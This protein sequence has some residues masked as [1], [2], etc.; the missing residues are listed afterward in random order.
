MTE[1]NQE[2]ASAEEEANQFVKSYDLPVSTIV[3]LPKYKW[4]FLAKMLQDFAKQQV[5]K[6]CKEKDDNIIKKLEFM[7]DNGLGWKD[8]EN[9][10]LPKQ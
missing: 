5:E 7:I 2:K 8:M 6:A 3:Q 4:E 9:D 1:E 10:N